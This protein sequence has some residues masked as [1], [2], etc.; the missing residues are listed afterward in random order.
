MR[1]HGRPEIIRCDPCSP[2]ASN[3][4]GR[5]SALS[6]WWLEQGIDVEFARPAKL[7]GQS[8]RRRKLIVAIAREFA[9]DWWRLRI[10]RVYP[11]DLG[12]QLSWPS[13]A[14]LR[15]KQPAEANAA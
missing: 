3:G 10:E 12:L 5:L 9:V 8:V 15:G 7:R 6:F 14:V 13:A 11:E 1:C 4:L 2:F